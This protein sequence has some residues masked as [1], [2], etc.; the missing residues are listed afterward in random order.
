MKGFVTGDWGMPEDF[1]PTQLPPE[2]MLPSAE[3]MPTIETVAEAKKLLAADR[4]VAL[5][6]LAEC[7]EDKLAHETAS[8]PWDPRELILGYRLLQM[9]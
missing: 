4:Q 2:E 3:K 7:S 5:D 6:M 8:A 9:V 1:D